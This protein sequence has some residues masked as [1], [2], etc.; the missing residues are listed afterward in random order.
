ML[1]GQEQLKWQRILDDAFITKAQFGALLLGLNDNMKKYAGMDDVLP[2]VILKTIQAYNAKGTQHKLL[3][4]ALAERLDNDEIVKLGCSLRLTTRPD[5][6]QETILSDSNSLLPF[7]NWL[8]GAA[9]VQL[10]VCRIEIPVKD[11]RTSYGTGFLVASDL[12]L[13]NCHVVDPILPVERNRQYT[14]PRGM[15]G[16]ALFRFDYRELPD[17][18]ISLGST[19]RLAADWCVLLR[20]NSPGAQE[21]QADELD[22][23]L[24]RLARPAGELAVGDFPTAGGAPRGWIKL[25][26]ERPMQFLVDHPLFIVQHP[27]SHPIKLAMESKSIEGVNAGRTRLRYRTNTDHGSSGSPCFDENWNL[28]ALHHSGDPNYGFSFNEGVPMEKIVQ[29]MQA[30]RIPLLPPPGSSAP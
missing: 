4:A 5:A 18:L 1:T 26:D 2:D 17:N 11:G 8:Q 9:R 20:P 10:A 15:A 19:Y 7:G 24:V 22:C 6:Q 30:E 23:A 12:V 16:A 14:G 13:T 28:L 3:L 25:P 21:P 29:Q 27:Q